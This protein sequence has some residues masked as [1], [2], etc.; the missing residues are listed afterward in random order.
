MGFGPAQ[1]GGGGGG[2]ATGSDGSAASPAVR[3][4]DANSGIY[5]TD[6]GR[7]T[8]MVRDG[9][10]ALRITTGPGV[11]LAGQVSLEGGLVSS[12]LAN[13]TGGAMNYR[14]VQ[15]S[16]TAG[17]GSPRILT[18]SDCGSSFNNTGTTVKA[19][20]E[21]GNLAGIFQDG[22][23]YVF[24]V[25]DA[26]GMRI[27]ATGSDTIRIG[28]QVS[29]AGGYVESVRVGS[30]LILAAVAGSNTW[31]AQQVT[32]T[33]RFDSTTS[34]GFA[35]TPTAWSSV[36]ITHTWDADADVSETA[37]AK[38]VGA[39]ITYRVRIALTGAPPAANL[40]VS[41]L[42]TPNGGTL[43]V[44]ETFMRGIYSNVECPLGGNGAYD[45]SDSADGLV[46][47]FYHKTNNNFPLYYQT[48]V[49]GTFSFITQT[50]PVTWATGDAIVC[51]FT[52]T[53]L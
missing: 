33:W 29:A 44:D 1:G 14:A 5:W 10:P 27:Q 6:S 39:E 47:P 45:D 40:I 41:T 36:A 52:V 32:G 37:D 42:G 2:G 19:G 38:Q 4:T 15:E 51:E 8:A 31:V 26:D 7:E 22:Y 23:F 9:T 46:F 13:F 30:T 48:G 28:D 43:A 17:T 16:V 53:A 21:L 25:T 18:L 50:A 35:Y 24:Q 20:F 12:S 11:A 34:A 49:T 3:G